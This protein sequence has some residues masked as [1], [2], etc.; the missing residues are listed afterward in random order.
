M[1][2]PPA[3]RPRTAG[4][5]PGAPA[6][7]GSHVPQGGAS[8]AAS[9]ATTAPARPT[10]ARSTAT[11]RAA[12]GVRR[13]TSGARAQG[14]GAPRWVSGFLAGVQGALLSLLAVVMP[15][16]AA[17]VA[18]SADPA[19]DGIAWT[20]SAAVGAAFWLMGH[21]GVV[22]A[23]G[24]PV[25][26][27]P[28]GITAL[29]LFCGYASARR[30]S[31]RTVS[32]WL[33]GIGGYAAVV[34]VVLL[35]AG[36]SGPLGAGLG[37]VLRLAVGTA[38]VAALG[39]G[40]G[41]ARPRRVRAATQRW[42]SR[43]PHPV[44]SGVVA[45]TA[46]AALLLGAAALLAAFW[47]LSGRAAAGDVV[48]GLGVDTFGGLLLAVAQTAVA[49][50]LAVWAL[51][52]L[53]GPGF[54]VGAGTLYAPST[55][56]AGPLP[57]LPVLGALPV[58]SGGP[59]AWAPLVLVVAGAVAG[60][61]VR[62]RLVV[63][64]ARDPFVAVLAAGLT[65]SLACAALSALGGGAIGPGRLAVVGAAPGAVAAWVLGGAL[66]GAFVVAVPTDPTVRAAARR[67]CGQGWARLRGR[68]DV[69]LTAGGAG[70]GAG[71]DDAAP[72]GGPAER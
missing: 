62:R 59:L 50:N 33:A 44:R 22:V 56:V 31:H 8:P 15:A 52:W 10:P 60:L 42:W 48:A 54:A 17:Y 18:T 25:T 7:R 66:L 51:G 3:P 23:G 14:Q 34:L 58:E 19:V 32:A 57:A 46:G 47:V 29:A 69:D 24:T 11:A 2:R 67:A 43:V 36:P 37:A 71:T 5:R 68:A 55:V 38:A 63:V 72:A 41:T 40:A 45:G 26:L 64:R 28:L 9:A 6:A 61:L 70:A 21:G 13:L 12:A 27:V 16:L 65:T 39:L 20:R 49:P 35:L 1:S 4:A 53:A 30:S